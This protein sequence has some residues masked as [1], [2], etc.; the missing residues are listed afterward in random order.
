MSWWWGSSFGGRISTQEFEGIPENIWIVQVNCK[1][2]GQEICTS[3]LW[4]QD[5]TT[6]SDEKRGPF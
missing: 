2:R 5:K 6:G 3:V 4:V 1:K